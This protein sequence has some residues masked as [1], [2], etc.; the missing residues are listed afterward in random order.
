MSS[1]PLPSLHAIL[2]WCI[3]AL[4]FD[5]VEAKTFYV[6]PSG[7]DVGDGSASAPF[8]T[9]EKA[10]DAVREFRGNSP[11]ES[12]TVELAGGTYVLETPLLFEPQDSGTSTAPVVWQGKAGER[13]V[14]SGAV[15]LTDWQDE[16]NGLFSASCSISDPEAG[17]QLFIE[18]TLSPNMGSATH[19]T[20]QAVSKSSPM[21][22]FPDPLLDVRRAIRARAPNRDPENFTASYFWAKRAVCKDRKCMEYR[23]KPGDL[24]PYIYDTDGKIHPDVQLMTY[25]YWSTSFNRIADYDPKTGIVKFPRSAGSFYPPNHTRWHVENCRAALD[26]PGEWYFDRKAGRVFYIPQKDEDLSRDAVLLTVCPRWLI[27][28]RGDWENG[29]LVEWLTFRNLVFSYSDADLSPDY[30][31]SVQGAHTQRGAINAVGLAH[32]RIENCEFSHLGEN[33]ITLLEGC[34]ENTIFQNHIFDTGAGGISLPAVP[35]GTPHELAVTRKNRIE[36]NLIHHTGELFHSA[37][38]IFLAGMAQFNTIAHND[39]SNTPWSAMQLGWSW[40]A[41]KAYSHHNDVGWNHL[42]HIS[43]GVMNDLAGIYTL[44]DTDGTRLHH[45]WIHDVRRYTFGNIGYGG[46]GLYGDAG[47]S[48]IVME[49]N[50]IHDTQDP[51]LHIHN[52]AYPYNAVYRNN[53]FAF[54]DS[55]AIVRNNVMHTDRDFGAKVER[56]ICLNTTGQMLSGNG[57]GLK[58]E[59]SLLQN[60][61]CFWSLTETPIFLGK[62]FNEWRTLAEQ[63]TESITEDPKFQDAET[64]DFRLRPD[65]PA[66]ALGFEPFDLTGPPQERA[67]IANGVP[68]SAPSRP[69]LRAGLYGSTEWVRLAAQ[70][71]H[72]PCETHAPTQETSSWLASFD[73]P[74]DMGDL[75]VGMMYFDSREGEGHPECLVVSREHAFRGKHALKVLDSPIHKNSYDPHII[76]QP[77]FPPGKLELSWAIRPEK[78]NV[79]LCETRQY[80]NTVGNYESG[81]TLRISENGTLSFREQTLAELPLECWTQFIIRF[82]NGDLKIPGK[83]AQSRTEKHS[84]NT[85][86]N[87]A[88]DPVGQEPSREWTLEIRSQDPVSGETVSQSFGPFPLP[89]NF[90]VLE[91]FAILSLSESETAYTV[92]EISVQ[93]LL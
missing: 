20:P 9:L 87:A 69:G 74:S 76:A 36:N 65:S 3:L 51:G 50:L 34:S 80:S 56:N 46:W 30:E 24:D 68:G 86:K 12:V 82:E 11:A 28:I 64:R 40:G 93:P 25:Q 59:K 8:A 18:R 14:I 2:F 71:V 89:E 13:A 85:K 47:T 42:H 60:R 37:C 63:D 62:T 45:N 88:Y 31:N 70:V 57:Y 54:S 16:G 75:P 26:V 78:G 73:D 15:H 39:V 6:S 92:D 61:N 66:L 90:R 91:W 44:G 83:T 53:I 35:Q 7:S 79:L 48:N 41:G 21:A 32:S 49:S 1:R 4:V 58:P 5:H 77:W 17:T 19:S 72:R 29:K 67:D 22:N 55:T 81:P 33:G 52:Y 38:G 23:L 43:R 10:R 27:E 84:L